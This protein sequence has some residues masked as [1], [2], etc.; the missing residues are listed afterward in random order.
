M[1]AVID[2][3]IEHDPPFW[4]WWMID[5]IEAADYVLGLRLVHRIVDLPF[6]H[7][8]RRAAGLHSIAVVHL[9]YVERLLRPIS[10][11]SASGRYQSR[12]VEQVTRLSRRWPG[13]IPRLFP[14]RSKGCA[15]PLRNP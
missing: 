6:D 1:E 7:P 11:R 13:G 8:E 2:Q 4:P 9:A 10:S 14:G 15:H 5:Q 3:C 12:A